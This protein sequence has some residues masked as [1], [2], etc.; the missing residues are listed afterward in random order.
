MTTTKTKAKLWPP[1]HKLAYTSGRHAWKVCCMVHRQRIRE[2]F[3]T[4][5]EAETRAA[6][7]RQQVENEGA[8]AFRFAGPPTRRGGTGGREVETIRG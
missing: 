1:I 2:A 3:P 7:I 8:A 5:E 6:Q 4:K